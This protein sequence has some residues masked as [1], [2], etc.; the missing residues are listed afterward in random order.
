METTGKAE[1]VGPYLY[2]LAEIWVLV[3]SS[4][5]EAPIECN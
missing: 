4:M 2:A 1:P 3:G 5:S